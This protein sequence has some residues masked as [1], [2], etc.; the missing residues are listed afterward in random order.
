MTTSLKTPIAQL[1]REAAQAP[2]KLRQ[3]SLPL[4]Q[5]ATSKKAKKAQGRKFREIPG[6]VVSQRTRAVSSYAPPTLLKKLRKALEWSGE[7]VA[8]AIDEACNQ[9]TISSYE[10]RSYACVSEQR[11]QELYDL[12]ATAYKARGGDHSLKLHHI[13]DAEGKAKL[14]DPAVFNPF[15][16]L[17]LEDA[18]PAAKDIKPK[19]KKVSAPQESHEHVLWLR[20][21]V[22][23]KLP[24]D[25]TKA[26]LEKVKTW[27][28]CL[29]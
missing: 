10:R 8:D 24:V 25:L 13:F 15:K 2:T 23:L 5:R 3:A 29:A 16:H 28:S 7:H 1:V 4:R 11:Q 21:D 20:D 14:Y 12:Y 9:A 18:E 19:K 22:A 27:V 26:E 17:G 6:P